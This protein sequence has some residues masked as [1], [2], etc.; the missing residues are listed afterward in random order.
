[1]R[2]YDFLFT[3]AIVAVSSLSASAEDFISK[4]TPSRLFNLGV[5]FG[6]NTSNRTVA[7]D[8]FDAWNCNSW[9][10][11]IDAGVVVDLNIKDYLAIQPGFFYESRSGNYAY[12]STFTANDG[13]KDYYAQMG[14]YREYGF[15]VPVMMSLRFNLSNY[16][17][18]NVDFGPDFAIKLHSSGDSKVQLV[19]Q[20]S[21]YD[22]PVAETVSTSNFDFGLKFGT[23]LTLK[24]HYSIG[25]HY[26]AGLSKAWKSDEMGGRNKTWVFSIGYDF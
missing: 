5:R 15:H 22:D 17:R 7:E 1:M 6:V 14:H 8:A 19:S 24:R 12:S 3:A 4:E 16:I 21:V 10:T 2:L 20:P 18:W 13:V 23:G 9:G 26:I 25:V 11:G